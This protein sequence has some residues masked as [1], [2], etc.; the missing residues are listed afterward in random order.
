MTTSYR[1]RL[2]TWITLLLF[3]VALMPASSMAQDSTPDAAPE[4]PAF[5]LE[6]VGQDGTYFTITQ[7]PGTMQEFTVAFG[8]GGTSP[9]T[10]LTYVADAY[11]LVNGGFGVKT[12]DDPVTEPTTWIDYPTETREL[13]PGERVERTFTISVPEGTAPGQYIAAI[14]IQTAE[15]IAVGESDMLRQ[16]IKKSIAVFITVPGPETPALEIGEARV[17]QTDTSN[18]LVIDIRNPGDVFLNPS[19]TVTM[20]TAAG[21]PVLTSPIDMGPVYAGTDTTLELA[22]PTMLPSGAYAVAVSLEDEKTGVGAEEPALSVTVAEPPAAATPA[23]EPVIF[24]AV[25]L[26]P[27][28]DPGTDALQA[29]NISVTL[30]NPGAAIPSARLTL[31][32]TRDGELVEDYPLN[33]SLV[34]QADTTEIQQRYVPLGSWQ[35]GTYEFGLTLEAVDPNTGQVTVLATLAVEDTIVVP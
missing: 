30:D 17:T 28:T 3:A 32:V 33:S 35:A 12:A 2:C 1:Q 26:D 21:D 10:A 4:P 15:S 25:T 8:N 9:V 11:T 18:N 31:H 13:A 5:L 19:G 34:V 14:S 27:M 29:V 6:P 23:A 7:D 20:T 16:I 22:I 24:Q